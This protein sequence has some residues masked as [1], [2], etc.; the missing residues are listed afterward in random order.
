MSKI[1]KGKRDDLVGEYG[2]DESNEIGNKINI[3]FHENQLVITNA[4]TTS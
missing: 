2:L 4:I 1:A 3:L